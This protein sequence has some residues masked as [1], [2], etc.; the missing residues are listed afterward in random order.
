MAWPSLVATPQQKRIHDPASYFKFWFPPTVRDLYP[1]L[2]DSP[3]ITP[4]V[5]PDNILA[6]KSLHLLCS[7]DVTD[8]GPSKV[9]YIVTW[10]KIVRFFG[11][12][13]GKLTLLANT[14][15]ETAIVVNFESAEFTLGD[16]VSTGL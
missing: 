12:T 5:P 6:S 4:V 7:Y 8:P 1:T 16:T 9:S 2:A 11:G 15:E 13:P 10:Y 3:Q 14:T